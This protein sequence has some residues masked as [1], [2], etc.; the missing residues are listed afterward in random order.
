MP[1]KKDTS[2]S[3]EK[4]K[5]ADDK[6]KKLCE[7]KYMKE[8]EKRS[9]LDDPY[10]SKAG[11]SK[12]KKP[13]KVKSVPSHVSGDSLDEEGEEE[14]DYYFPIKKFLPKKKDPKKKDP[15]KKEEEEEAS[16]EEDEFWE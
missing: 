14:S 9:Y 16:E 10:K 2:K 4:S 1:P 3:T 5:E 11:S 13:K 15:K 12:A 7:E 6:M 8:H